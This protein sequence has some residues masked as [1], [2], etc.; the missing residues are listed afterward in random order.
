VVVPAPCWPYR[1]KVASWSRPAAHDPHGPSCRAGTSTLPVVSCRPWVVP[2][3]RVVGRAAG[4]WA[5]CTPM[6]AKGIR[7]GVHCP[8]ISHLLFSDDCLLFTH[9]S[10]R[11]G[12]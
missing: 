6:L 10:E 3:R 7:V 4:P 5:I 1:A 11:G 8:W 2:K 9:A 12:Q